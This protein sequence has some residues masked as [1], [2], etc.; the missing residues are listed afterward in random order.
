MRA[1]SKGAYLR[2]WW[3]NWERE[4]I[5]GLGVYPQVDLQTAF[6]FHSS[7]R[8]LEFYFSFNSNDDSLL[9]VPSCPKNR[10]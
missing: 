6:G 9:R 4:K 10:S 7:G 3:A 8:Q 1:K 2:W 5:R